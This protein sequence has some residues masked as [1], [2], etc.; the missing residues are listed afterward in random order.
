MFA[1]F[2]FISMLY[3]TIGVKKAPITFAW[4]PTNQT[5]EIRNI[6]IIVPIQDVVKTVTKA[7]G[8]EMISNTSVPKL[9]KIP[10]TRIITTA[11]RNEGIK[12]VKEFAIPGGMESGNLITM[13]FF[14][15]VSYTHLRAHETS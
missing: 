7:N 3:K 4:I 12:A 1:P 6:I 13:F 5:A 10:L 11:T 8:F 14:T 9:I 15:P 2:I